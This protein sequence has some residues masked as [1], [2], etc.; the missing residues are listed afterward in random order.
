MRVLVVGTGGVGA[1]VGPIAQRRPCF[2]RIVWADLDPARPQALVDRLG[3]P[4]RFGAAR[5][6]ASDA[7]AV[8]A[9]ILET[10]A[11]AVLNACDPR[12]NPPLFEAA[13]RARCTY[14]DMAASLSDPEAGVKLADAQLEEHERW[15][16]AG[17]LAL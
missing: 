12:F 9:L 8:A 15:R 2:E 4:D 1:A 17:L 11:D 13:F 14:L 10:R 7:D 6:D 5:V 16:D 3:E